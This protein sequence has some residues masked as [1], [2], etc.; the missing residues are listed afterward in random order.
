MSSLFIHNEILHAKSQIT[1][2]VLL[3]SVHREHP[4]RCEFYYGK[5]VLHGNQ[6]AQC[7]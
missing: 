1:E 5:P 3:C 4:N 6:S 2:Y 7:L